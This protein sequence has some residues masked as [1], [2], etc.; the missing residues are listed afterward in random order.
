ML[1]RLGFEDGARALSL[2]QSAPLAGLI[3]LEDDVTGPLRA[4]AYTPEPNQ[5][6]LGG[7]PAA[8]G[9]RRTRPRP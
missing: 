4:L 1:A 2:A 7:R 5:A 3:D 6:L 9:D 8:R